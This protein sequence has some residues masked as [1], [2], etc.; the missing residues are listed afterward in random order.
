MKIRHLVIKEIY[1][2]KL[3]FALGLISIIFAVAVVAGALGLLKIHDLRTREIVAQKEAAT[4]QRMCVLEDDY[5]K[6][7]KDMGFNLLILPENQNLADLY[8]ADYATHYMPEDYVDTLAAS[9]IMTIRHLLPSL[10]QKIKWP[11]YQRTILLIGTR[12]EIPLLH[13]DPK[14]P[15]L[16]PVLPGTIV[17]GYELHRSLK[18]KQGDAVHLLGQK[19]TVS[20]C[21]P[22]RGNKDDITV[23]IDLKTAQDLLHKPGKINA[24]LALKCHCVNN[25][26]SKIRDDIATILPGVQVIEEVTKVVTRAEARDRAAQEA[27]AAIEAEKVNRLRHRLEQENLAAMLVPF[28]V[29]GVAVW[30]GLLFFINTRNRRSEIGILRAIGLRAR[31]IQTLFLLKALLMG[32]LGAIIGFSFSFGVLT[33]WHNLHWNFAIFDGQ[34]FGFILLLAPLLALIASW[35]PALL[36]SRQD[37][38]T[39]LREE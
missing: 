37:P 9:R 31:Q 15:I 5:R 26:I 34:L 2:R 29:I 11:E 10:Q 17:L 7:M 35:F 20:Q 27:R 39:V 6:I 24:I 12:G 23:W 13:R 38:A 16:V 22:E 3:N 19:L 30:I 36:A 21:N 18:L 4:R 33:W 25:S 1:Q 32:W 28:V 8:A 14:K